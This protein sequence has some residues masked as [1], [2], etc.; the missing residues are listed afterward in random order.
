MLLSCREME[1]QKMAHAIAEQMD[2]AGKTA[3]A[4][5]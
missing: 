2:F 5:A 1:V 3:A 4:T